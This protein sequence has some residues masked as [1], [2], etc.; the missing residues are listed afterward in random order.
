MPTSRR[1]PRWL[2]GRVALAIGFVVV[3][4]LLWWGSAVP[5]DNTS[6]SDTHVYLAWMQ[7]WSR[8]GRL[9]GI[10]V[11]WV[12][13]IGAL[14][15]MQL[16]YLS[17]PGSY[18]TAWV[19]MVTVLDALA[20]VLLARRSRSSA[21]WWLGCMALLGPVGVAHVDGVALPFAVAGVLAIRRH[22]AIASALFT[23]A[24]GNDFIVRTRVDEQDIA[25]VAVG[26]RA[27]VGGEDFG[28]ATLGGHVMAISP[29][30]QR[31]DDP[32]NTSRQV[33]TT[34]GLDKRLPFLRDGM[35]VDVDIVTH[36]ERNVLTIPAE[37]LRTDAQGTYVFVVRDG[38]AVRAAVKLGTQ[39]D[40]QAVV[41]SG[42]H[43]GD[44]VVAEKT[45]I[46]PGARVR[47][48]GDAT[49]APAGRASP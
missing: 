24:A 6:S 13:P 40:T 8:T 49:S 42:L 9:V 43:D 41:K 15:P 37:A 2:T 12:Y 32:S 14:P 20:L 4:L 44:T 46:V 19:G 38:H 22:P 36:D 1:L 27:I 16:A 29:I 3:H 26:Q 47:P 31:S 11:P 48:A 30:A 5:I 39:N 23:L 35:S 45:D 21:W 17:G 25:S 33:V 7:A 18:L 34:I 28:R 10:D